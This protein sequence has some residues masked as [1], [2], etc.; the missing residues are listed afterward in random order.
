MYRRLERSNVLNVNRAG[1]AKIGLDA[2]IEAVRL[3]LRWWEHQAKA[4]HAGGPPQ[5]LQI[6]ATYAKD[7]ASQEIGRCLEVVGSRDHPHRG[8]LDD[9]DR[10]PQDL[11][12]LLH[13]RVDL[14]CELIH[15]GAAVVFGEL[16]S[17]LRER[18]VRESRAFRLV[19][20]QAGPV[21]R[22]DKVLVAA[23]VAHL[24]VDST[25]TLGGVLHGQVNQLAEQA[26]SAWLA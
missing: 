25:Q 17:V 26:N 11:D 15:G 10:N 6:V 4:N 14:L 21:R 22:S 1:V 18:Q 13:N 8:L 12:R 20:F 16:D 24:V 2:N 19:A 7:T 3:L 5:K 23:R 9:D